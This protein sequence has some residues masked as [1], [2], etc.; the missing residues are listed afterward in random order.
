[1]PEIPFLDLK[2]AYERYGKEIEEAVLK[3]LR[4][5]IYLNG[6]ETRALEEELSAYLGVKHAIG[7]ASGT[8]ALYLILKALN[9]PEGSAILLP[10]FTFVATAEVVVRCGLKPVFVDIERSTGNLDLKALEKAYQECLQ[11]GER[12]SG[13][14]VVSLFGNPPALYEISNFCQKHNLYL[15]EDICQALGAG[16]KPAQGLTVQKVG[17]FGIASAT[18]FYPTKNLSCCGDGGMVFTDDDELALKIRAMKEHGQ[19]SPYHYL[20][21]GVNGRIDELQCAIL[22]VKFRYFEEELLLRKELA[23]IYEE[24][25][26]DLS[27]EVELLKVLEGAEPAFSLYSVRVKR[28]EELM[29]YL[30]R[31]GIQTRIYYHLPLHLQPVYKELGY[32]R[33]DLPETERLCEEILSL[34]FF[35]YLRKDEANYVVEKIRRFYGK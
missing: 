18:S 22:R 13:V 17:T 32:K 2:R 31:E 12:I 21:H 8:E 20:Y 7:V 11:R 9:L 33:G 5:G 3:V 28:R 30:K 24:G 15:I 1:M 29:E 10:S 23:R 34:P 26:R 6:P 35:P 4:K 16:I 14:I 19:V 25:L 27:P